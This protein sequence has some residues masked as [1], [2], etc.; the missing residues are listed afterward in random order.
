LTKQKYTLHNEQI[1][2]IR[3]FTLHNLTGVNQQIA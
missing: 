1:A 2:I 3:L